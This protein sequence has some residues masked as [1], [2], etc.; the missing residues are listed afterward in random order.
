MQRVVANRLQQSLDTISNYVN[1]TAK[2]L[3]RCS[4]PNI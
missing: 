2:V 1:Q 4:D 3:C